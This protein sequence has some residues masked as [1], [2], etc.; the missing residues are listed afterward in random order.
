M[1]D[2]PAHNKQDGE[3]GKWKHKAGC[4]SQGGSG[5]KKGCGSVACC[6]QLLKSGRPITRRNDFTPLGVKLE[7]VCVCFSASTN[8]RRVCSPKMAWVAMFQ[9]LLMLLEM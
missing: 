1:P 7:I 3:E 2:A 9:A 6:V 8:K 4:R 5:R